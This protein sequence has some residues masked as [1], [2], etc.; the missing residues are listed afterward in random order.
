MPVGTT[1]TAINGTHISISDAATAII[2]IDTEITFLPPD[3]ETLT[4]GSTAG[5]TEATADAPGKFK[6]G[7]EIITYTGKTGTTLTLSL[8][9]I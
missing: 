8:I 9:H 5:F 1:V 3:S 4:V 7:D 6:L 2:P